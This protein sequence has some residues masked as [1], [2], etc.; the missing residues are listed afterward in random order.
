M[1]QR[2]FFAGKGCGRRLVTPE[3]ENVSW[4]D[5][6]E[7]SG[8][9]GIKIE[10]KNNQKGT[11]M[12]LICPVCHKPLRIEEKRL[13]CQ[14]HHSFDRAKSG[15]VNLL[16]SNGKHSKLPGDNKLMVNAR[17]DFL[18][19]GY[20]QPLAEA[21]CNEAA[22]CCQEAG[23][24]TPDILDAGCGEGYYTNAV[25]QA[26]SS[27]T[28]PRMVGIDI[29][30]FALNAAAKKNHEAEFLVG[31]VFH[32][33]VADSACDLLFNLF[34]PYCGEEFLRVLKK[35]GI[36]VMVIPSRKHLW[37]LKEL[38]YDSPYENED[39]DYQLS[40][41][42]L[43]RVRRL[44]EQITLTSREDIQNLF[45]MTPYYYKTSEENSRRLQ[46]CGR[47][48]TRIEFEILVYQK[49]GKETTT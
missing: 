30:K 45:M 2:V 3:S 9:S 34:A 23:W 40:G 44:A 26:L 14:N 24:K 10:R 4:T 27:L 48:T 22:R 16:L 33:P 28:K 19:K 1:P 18:Q 25:Y 29:S 8:D 47:L 31:S 5:I 35:D 32:L 49:D 43:L 11:T 38:V 42:Q 37:E 12:E 41:F 46:G 36:M 20:Y 17:R 15:Y 21:L 13:V 7:P 6:M 39:R